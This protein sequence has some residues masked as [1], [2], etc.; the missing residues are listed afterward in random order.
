MCFGVTALVPRTRS[1][2]HNYRESDCELRVQSG[3]RIIDLLVS[4]DSEVR[5]VLQARANFGIGTLEPTRG[6]ILKERARRISARVSKDYLLR[7]PWRR[8]SI[9]AVR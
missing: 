8:G 2:H 7:L 9:D 4:F 5:G 1:S 3:T 6:V